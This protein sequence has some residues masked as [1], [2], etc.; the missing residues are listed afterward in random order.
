V[1]LS[2]NTQI[3][4]NKCPRKDREVF[5]EKVAFRSKQSH[6]YSRKSENL[7]WSKDRKELWTASSLV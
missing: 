4:R 3:S 7:P 1:V 2:E 5:R 6:F